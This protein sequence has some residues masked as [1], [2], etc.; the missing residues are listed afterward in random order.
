MKNPIPPN[1][2]PKPSL[3]R[4]T[5][6]ASA[7][8]VTAGFTIVPR[9]VLG[10]QAGTPAP[11][12]KVNIACVGIGGMG[13]S[14]LKNCA[15]E[16]IVALCDINCTLSEPMFAL[17]PNAKQYKNY[18]V[19]LDEQKDIDAI[20][21]ATPDHSHAVITMAAI[22]LKK[23]VY[24]QKPLTHSV[25]ETRLLTETARKQSVQSQIRNQKHS[26]KNIRLLCK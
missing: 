5:F 6:L 20:I 11:S 16:N 21:V 26:E 23:H 8:A 7:A 18:R 9:H 22:T 2:D 24:V 4:R 1:P 10:G 25:Y 17:Y 13:K 19:M 12:D 14:N 3:P 15:E